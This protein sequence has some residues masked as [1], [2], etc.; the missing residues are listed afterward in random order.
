MM[1]ARK[2][3][4]LRPAQIH[5]QKHLRPILR[6]GAAGAGLDGHD[7]VQAVALAGEKGLVSSSET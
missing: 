7:G 2:P 6:L 1:V 4:F 3:L 5:A